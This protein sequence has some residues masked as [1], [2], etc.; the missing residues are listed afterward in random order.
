M[1]LTGWVMALLM[2]VAPVLAQAQACPGFV[3][4]P[5]VLLP[6]QS[7]PVDKGCGALC[8]P[9]AEQIARGCATGSDQPYADTIFL[10]QARALPIEA[11]A[12]RA[13]A[14]AALAE[15]P[16]GVAPLI[17]GLIQS[18]SA[19][20]R[21]AAALQMALAAVRSGQ[22]HDPRF[23][24]ALEVMGAATDLEFPTS[25]LTFM[26]AL[27]AEADGALEGAQL[28][29]RQAAEQEPRFFNALALDLRLALGSGEHLRGAV[30][31]FGQRT[32]CRREFE[33]L[34]TA[35]SQIADL[36][37][38]PRVAA[39][40]DLYLARHLISPDTAPGLL[41]ARVYLGVLSQRAEFARAARDAFVRGPGPVCADEMTAELDGLLTL[42]DRGDDQ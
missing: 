13:L 30:G 7:P 8:K 21:Y 15:T 31:P 41:A 10:R 32:A 1:T 6:Q 33:G 2:L 36:E 18:E 4:A 42:L 12:R 11:E 40:L 34:L 29:A 37:P 27:Q 17:A 28:L 14:L 9:L 3:V 19:A 16:E 5:C 20:I 23:A 26:R 38:C 24:A 35:L 39:H 25:D 22:I